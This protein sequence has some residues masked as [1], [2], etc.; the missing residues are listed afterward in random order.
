MSVTRWK[1]DIMGH[2]VTELDGEY[3]SYAD[4]AAV[5]AELAAMQSKRNALAYTVKLI[6]G[7]RDALAVQIADRDV[8]PR[9]RYDAVNT[10]WLNAKTKLKWLQDIATK[11]IDTLHQQLAQVREALAAVSYVLVTTRD[12]TNHRPGCEKLTAM[13]CSCGFDLYGAVSAHAM[14]QAE[15]VLAGRSD[16]EGCDDGNI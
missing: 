13:N 16:K 15:S 6:A 5:E 1:S 4:Y 7:E 12:F 14:A 8:V 3:V 2:M 10:D 11:E 9:S